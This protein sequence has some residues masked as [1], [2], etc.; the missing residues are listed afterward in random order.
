MPDLELTVCGRPEKEED[1]FE[2]YRKELTQ[3]P[4]I[5][6]LGWIKL[7]SSAFAE[8]AAT[9]AAVVYPSSSEGGGGSVIH[10]MHAGLL[11]VC[12]PDASVD[13]EHFG[14]AIAT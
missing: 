13:L 8:I 4:N 12:T 6:L 3:L 14:V 1:F 2:A 5:R 11:P 9:H 7:Q 10:C